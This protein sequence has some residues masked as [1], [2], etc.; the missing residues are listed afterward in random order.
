LDDLEVIIRALLKTK[1]INIFKDLKKDSINYNI[2]LYNIAKNLDHICVNKGDTVFRIGEKG[3]KFYIIIKG[4]IQILKIVYSLK[5]LTIEEYLEYVHNFNKMNESH[6]VK[7]MMQ[8]NRERVHIDKENI[9]VCLKNIFLKRL[10]AFLIGYPKV[11]EI[12]FFFEKHAKKIEDFKLQNIYKLDDSNG[13]YKKYLNAYIKSDILKLKNEVLFKSFLDNPD[14]T[15]NFTLLYYENFMEMGE[16]QF[17][18]DYALD[19]NTGRT[20]TLIAKENDTHLALISKEIYA[21][22]I[23]K[24]KLKLTSRYVEF[25]YNSFFFEMLL[26]E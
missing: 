2:N 22:Y 15:K 20:A 3:D 10:K 7:K 17:F 24:E 1:L 26:I 6:I 13:E 8:M 25:I 4:S 9:E 18:G 21:E 19:S 14:E 11:L 12:E 16:G 5:V 23:L